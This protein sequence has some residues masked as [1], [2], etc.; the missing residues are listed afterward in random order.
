MVEEAIRKSRSPRLVTFLLHWESLLKNRGNGIGDAENYPQPISE[1]HVK[2]THQ[3]EYTQGRPATREKI[4]QYI[5][6][7]QGQPIHGQ[8]VQEAQGSSQ[9]QRD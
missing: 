9:L 7:K 4:C 1:D 8:V 6:A 5:Y 2:E 3:L